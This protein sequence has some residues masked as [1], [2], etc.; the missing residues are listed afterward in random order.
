MMI[1]TAIYRLG[2]AA[3]T[4]AIR[5]AAR[6]ND[7]AKRFTDGRKGLLHKIGDALANDTRPRL[8]MHCASLGEFEQGRPV[9]EA[10]RRQYPAY[11]VV[12]T[13]FSPSGYEVRKDYDGAD[14]VFYLPMDTPANA[15]HFLDIVR[16]ALCLFVKYEFWYFYLSGLAQRGIPAILV[17][18]VFRRDQEF[19]K[20]YGGLHRRM[21]RCFAHIFVQDN[22]SLGLLHKIKITNATLGGD[23][24][25]DRVI[26]AAAKTEAVPLAVCI[27][28]QMRYLQ[29]CV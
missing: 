15:R 6:F 10:L 11:C 23:T 21:L 14:H 3:Y 26:A 19:F 9:L 8:W 18:A 4:T 2:I 20:W 12:V 5:I 27:I 28:I 13:F 22:A 24:R 25:F 1:H 29:I 16:P 17:S 7:K